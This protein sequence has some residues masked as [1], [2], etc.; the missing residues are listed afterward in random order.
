M[1]EFY[2][3]W[4]HKLFHC[5]T[6]WELKPHFQC[7]KCGKKYRCYWE[8]NDIVGVGKDYCDDCVKILKSREEVH[9]EW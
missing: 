4:R 3:R 7:P 9:N 5:P 6:F 1:K 8:G 2:S